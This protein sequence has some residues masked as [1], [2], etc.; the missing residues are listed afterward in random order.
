LQCSTGVECSKLGAKFVV[1]STNSGVLQNQVL[2][3][4]TTLTEAQCGSTFYNGEA[5]EVEL[6][7]A[8]GILGCRYTFIVMNA[9]NFTLDPDD[10]D[11]IFLLT[12]AAGDR[13]QADAVGESVVLEAVVGG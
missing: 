11:Q 5:T 1:T 13:I 12:D 9:S 2:A 3:T 4:A 7:D 8:D 10:A 6:P